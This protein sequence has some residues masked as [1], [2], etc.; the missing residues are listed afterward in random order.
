MLR[1]KALRGEAA[2]DPVLLG[3][4]CHAG[5]AAHGGA[6]LL[7]AVAGERGVARHLAQGVG[8]LHTRDTL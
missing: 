2:A 6:R 4:G 8:L 5:H 1:I 3:E 7:L